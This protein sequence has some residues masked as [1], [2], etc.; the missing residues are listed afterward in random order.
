MVLA[1]PL[2]CRILTSTR[3]FRPSGRSLIARDRLAVAIAE[4]LNE[5]A[6]VNVVLQDQVVNNGLRAGARLVP[7]L[8]R[9]A[10]RVGKSDDLYE[11]AVGV[12]LRFFALGPRCSIIKCLFARGVDR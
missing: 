10:R 9:I 2:F 11:P 7:F 8:S 5:T 4:W 12:T 1:I 6:K 3:R